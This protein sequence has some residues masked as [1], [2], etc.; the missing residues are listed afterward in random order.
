MTP[1][2]KPRQGYHKV[3]AIVSDA[4]LHAILQVKAERGL[5]SLHAA[6]SFVLQEWYD[7]C[8]S[9][10]LNPAQPLGE[11]NSLGQSSGVQNP[12]GKLREGP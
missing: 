5:P 1:K 6:A 11:D 12:P 4:V 10:V 7:K 9:G 2:G 8:R 3:A